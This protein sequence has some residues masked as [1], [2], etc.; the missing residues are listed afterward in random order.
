VATGFA[1]PGERPQ[2]ER[3]VYKGYQNGLGDPLVIDSSNTAYPSTVSI[4]LTQDMN[5]LYRFNNKNFPENAWW[6]LYQ[7]V[8]AFIDYLQTP[9]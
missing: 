7:R 8:L 4:S 9:K 2:W 3:F 1:K 6:N 5:I